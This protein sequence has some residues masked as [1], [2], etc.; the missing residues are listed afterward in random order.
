MT[1]RTK[2]SSSTCRG[3]ALAAVVAGALLTGCGSGGGGETCASG[4]VT[5]GNTPY[6]YCAST[7]RLI[8]CSEASRK[9]AALVA[10]KGVAWQQNA[11]GPYVLDADHQ[12]IWFGA[13]AP[14]LMHVD[15]AVIGSAY[16]DAAG[17]VYEAGQPVA[18]IRGVRARDGELVAALVTPEGTWADV[19]LSGEGVRI[20]ATSVPALGSDGVSALASAPLAMGDPDHPLDEATLRSGRRP[21]REPDARI[22][23]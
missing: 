16:A 10:S 11:N 15:R 8:D 20:V 2:P 18:T 12:A 3:L 22:D 14:H 13:E 19:T 21:V 1:T 6:C 4:W 17:N 9:T 5:Y 23:A 7:D